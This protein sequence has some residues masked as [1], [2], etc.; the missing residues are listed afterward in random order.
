MASSFR[1]STSRESKSS[2]ARGAVPPGCASRR[3]GSSCGAGRWGPGSAWPAGTGGTRAARWRRWPPSASRATAAAAGRRR[4]G[5]RAARA[6][7]VAPLRPSRPPRGGAGGRRRAAPALGPCVGGGFG[8]DGRRWWRELGMVEWIE[9]RSRRRG[10]GFLGG[11]DAGF[12]AWRSAPWHGRH[13]FFIFSFLG[14]GC[15]GPT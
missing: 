3:R 15:G 14:N 5:W 9:I 8:V 2:L 1:N 6:A 4:G 7:P 13:G 11:G 10:R 12:W